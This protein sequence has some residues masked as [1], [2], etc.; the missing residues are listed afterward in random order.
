MA[1]WGATPGKALIELEV[2]DVTTGRR[3]SLGRALVRT[4]VMFGLPMATGLT[5]SV[6]RHAAGV[7][8]GGIEQAV[9]A[10]V[11]FGAFLAL[12]IAAVRSPGKRPLWDR[13]ARTMVRYRT[14]RTL[15]APD[16]P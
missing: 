10:L 15:L 1:R 13:L 16:R 7:E 3:P 14:A 11:G 12:A 8:L 6:V 4:L 9:T 5:A 2:V